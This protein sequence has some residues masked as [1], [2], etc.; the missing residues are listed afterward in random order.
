MTIVSCGALLTAHLPRTETR[1]PAQSLSLYQLIQTDNVDAAA[2]AAAAAAGKWMLTSEDVRHYIDERYR[3]LPCPAEAQPLA[4]PRPRPAGAPFPDPGRAAGIDGPPLVQLVPIERRASVG[5]N[6]TRGR[7]TDR[8]TDRRPHG[9][10]HRGRARRSP[11]RSTAAR[12]VTTRL[13]IAHRRCRLIVNSNTFSFREH[14]LAPAF[15]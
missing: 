7:P 15:L 4:L 3:C 13:G 9:A 14:A 12:L 11:G 1:P 6:W 2:V 5:N 10:T 8:R